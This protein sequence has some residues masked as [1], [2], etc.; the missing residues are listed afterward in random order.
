MAGMRPILQWIKGSEA[1]P[2]RNGILWRGFGV[3]PPLG[4]RDAGLR[5]LRPGMGQELDCAFPGAAVG[6]GGAPPAR[7][8]VGPENPAVGRPQQA[9]VLVRRPGPLRHPAWIG[10][11]VFDLVGIGPEHRELRVER[12]RPVRRCKDA[13]ITGKMSNYARQMLAFVPTTANANLERLDKPQSLEGEWKA[14]FANVRTDSVVRRLVEYAITKPEF[15]VNDAQAQLKVSYAA[16]NTAA[17]ALTN[18][19]ILAVPEDVTRNRLFHAE[20]V[21]GIYST[22]S[23]RS[24]GRPP[25]IR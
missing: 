24:P 14:R 7:R 12:Q 1:P 25:L 3:P 13:R 9:V 11:G 21:L 2:I 10:I 22:A 19:G 16:A 23:D 18:A 17:Q 4:Q 6:I 8:A 15:T 5:S 20:E